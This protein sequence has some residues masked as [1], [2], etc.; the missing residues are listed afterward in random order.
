MSIVDPVWLRLVGFRG[1]RG[2]FLATTTTVTCVGLLWASSSSS[3]VQP[4]VC[5]S[6]SGQLALPRR[7]LC[8]LREVVVEVFG[9]LGVR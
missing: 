6:N 4:F 9:D 8:G 3:Q 7:G 1:R 2:G 5:G